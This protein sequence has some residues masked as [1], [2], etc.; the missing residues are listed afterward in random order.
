MAATV[1]VT[2]TGTPRPRGQA[3]RGKA[4]GGRGSG[5]A[6]A[7]LA[8]PSWPPMVAADQASGPARGLA[9]LLGMLLGRT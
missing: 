7:Y 4:V 9:L 6:R 3:L 8:A 2:R 1:T 5:F